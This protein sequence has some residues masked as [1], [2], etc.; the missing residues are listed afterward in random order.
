MEDTTSTQ[1]AVTNDQLNAAARKALLAM[2]EDRSSERMLNIQLAAVEMA[3]RL[4]HTQ[5]DR[6][7]TV[8]H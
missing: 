6:S 1:S 3:L 2:L 4:T 8:L 7:N 5:S